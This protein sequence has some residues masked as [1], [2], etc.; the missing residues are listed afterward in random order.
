MRN[1]PSSFE[2]FDQQ[3]KINCR[4]AFDELIGKDL[5]WK[6]NHKLVCVTYGIKR[7]Q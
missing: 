2:L 3:K 4:V 5:K 1:I 7:R 6:S